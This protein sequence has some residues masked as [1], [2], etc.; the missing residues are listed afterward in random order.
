MS[1]AGKKN[2]LGVLIDDANLEKLRA[3]LEAA[4]P[5]EALTICRDHSGKIDLVLTD[6]VMPGMSGPDLVKQLLAQRPGLKVLFS[7]GYT[8]EAIA[9]RGELLSGLAFLPKPFT[10]LTLARKV[11]EVLDAPVV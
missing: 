10:P 7:S 11:R 8:G 6:V 5:S 9:H 2:I 1:A 4:L 3:V